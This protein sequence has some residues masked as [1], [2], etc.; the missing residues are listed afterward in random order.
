MAVKTKHSFHVRPATAH[1]VPAVHDLIQFHAQKGRMILRGFDELYADLRSFMIAEDRQKIVGCASVH[2]FWSDLAELKCVAVQE[3]HQRQG[4]GSSIVNA[5]H[6][7]LK[8][9][10]I[11]KSFALT[12]ATEFFEHLGYKVVPKD[13][14]PRFIWGECVRCPSFPVCNEEALVFDLK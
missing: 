1:D 3:G 12:G 8:R 2:I 10:G 11:Q 7:D 14:L 13:S 4:V 9:L 5:C 6:A